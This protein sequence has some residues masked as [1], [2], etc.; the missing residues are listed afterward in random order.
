MAIPSDYDAFSTLLLADD[1]GM[2]P[3]PLVVAPDIETITPEEPPEETHSTF[4]A[5]QEDAL[6]ATYIDRVEQ[7]DAQAEINR[8]YENYQRAVI[9]GNVEEADAER[10][11][12]YYA[13]FFAEVITRDELLEKVSDRDAAIAYLDG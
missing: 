5:Q 1:F 13:L 9:A 11:N 2:L 10:D 4:V 6:E 7:T 12:F 8:Y 3:P